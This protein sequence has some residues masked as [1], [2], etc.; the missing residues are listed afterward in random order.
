MGEVYQQLQR[1]RELGVDICFVHMGIDPIVTQQ[2]IVH[3]FGNKLTLQQLKD[4]NRVISIRGW[5]HATHTLLPEELI[6]RLF[7]ME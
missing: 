3:F 5:G 7:P 2:D 4:Q 1:A 6:R